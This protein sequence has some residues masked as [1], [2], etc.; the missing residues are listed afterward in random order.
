MKVQY[1]VDKTRSLKNPWQFK[2]R[3]DE[4]NWWTL[5]ELEYEPKE[6][7]M[8]MLKKIFTRSCAIYHDAF[9][10]PKFNLEDG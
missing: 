3:V 9:D 2:V 10:K 7:D 1:K 5:A 6:E 8:Q 4:K